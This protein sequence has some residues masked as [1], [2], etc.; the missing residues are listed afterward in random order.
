MLDSLTTKELV[1]LGTKNG[2]KVD[3]RWKKDRIVKTLKDAGVKADKDEKKVGGKLAEAVATA[4][5]RFQASTGRIR[6]RDNHTEPTNFGPIQHVGLVVDFTATGRPD[7]MPSG[8]ISREFYPDLDDH[9]EGNEYC[10]CAKCLADVRDY[11][12][13]DKGGVCSRANVME[14]KIDSPVQPTGN[15]D[16]ASPEDVKTLVRTGALEAGPSGDPVVNAVKYEIQVGAKRKPIIDVL[17][18][19]AAADAEGEATSEDVLDAEVSL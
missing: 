17:E 5:V 1:E 10:S 6:I 18:A 11:I 3:G 8:G 9:D 15:W 14:S 2:V 12:A 4:P 16:N 13:A 19:I 7:A